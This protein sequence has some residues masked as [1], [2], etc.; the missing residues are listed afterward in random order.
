[1]HGYLIDH[2]Q[3]S[4]LMFSELEG[5]FLYFSLAPKPAV[6]EFFHYTIKL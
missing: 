6:S 3:K 5:K 2:I 1:M 4:N